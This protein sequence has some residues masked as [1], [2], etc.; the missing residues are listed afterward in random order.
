MA[1]KKK[2]STEFK[3]GGI[4]IKIGE[5]YILDHIPDPNS[6]VKTKKFPFEGSGVQ[7][8]VNFDLQKNIYDTGFYEGSYCLQAYSAADREELVPIYINQIKKPF[9]EFRNE[10]LDHSS[11]NEFWGQYRYE[12]YVNKEFDTSKPDELFELFQIII[13][14]LAIDK[15]ERNPFY[16][17]GAQFIVS[18]PQ[19]TKNKNKERSKTKL[20]AIQKL[21]VLADGDKDKLDLILNFVR[22]ESTNKVKK[23]DLKLIYFEVI[24]DPNSGLDF[25]ERFIEACE[26]YETPTGKERMEYFHAINELVKL[27]KIKKDRR[28]YVTENGGVFLGNTLQDISKFCLTKDSA[29]AKAIEE[30]IEQNPQ[31]RREV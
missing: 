25:S 31:V 18:N 24:N 15:N 17:Q 29:Q 13:Q 10:N 28:G 30:L 9:E 22:G 11:K 4:T 12:A 23:D 7:D 2:E 16:K 8:C 26:S 20:D 6:Q 27:R 5:K 14:G 21:A 3:V 1:F 19:I